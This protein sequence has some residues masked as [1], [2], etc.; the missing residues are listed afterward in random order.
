MRFPRVALS[1]SA[2]AAMLFGLL[3]A[4]TAV[5]V[6]DP[7]PLPG[8]GPRI[9]TR[10]YDPVCAR[11]GPEVRTFGNG[12]LADTAGY[13]VI[14]G[15]EC[16][17]D[18]PPPVVRGCPRQYD[19]VCARR[20]GRRQTFANDCLAEEAGYRVIRGGECRDDYADEGG[21]SGGGGFC[22]REYRP[23]CARRGPEVRTF[24]NDCE[25]R[26]ANYRVVSDGP[27]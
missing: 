17:P 2:F 26:S 1:L 11:R 5:V 20:G 25:A 12:C 23:V 27:C 4:C 7:G 18:R 19:P 3:S 8:P 24:G 14:R 10:E 16:G 9:C 13:R 21:Q 22:T 6:D 15:G